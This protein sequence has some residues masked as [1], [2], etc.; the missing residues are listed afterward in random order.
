MRA[1]PILGVVA[2]LGLAAADARGDCPT[3]QAACLLR[4]EGVAL[5]ANKQYDE[6]AAKFEASIM[7]GAS[8]RAELGYALALQGAGRLG[9]AFEAI[10]EADR[11]SAWE[12]RAAPADAEVHARSERIKYVLAD[13]RSRVGFIRVQ[14]PASVAPQQ[15]VAVQRAGRDVRD[16][17]A[18]I[19]VAPGEKL[20]AVMLTGARYESDAPVAAGG[21]AV[22]V[23]PVTGAPA[24]PARVQPVLVVAH[25]PPAPPASGMRFGIDLA[26]LPGS[27]EAKSAFGPVV[28]GALIMSPRVALTLR[29]GYLPHGSFTEGTA[30]GTV[31]VSGYELTGWTGANIVLSGALYAAIEVGA[32]SLSAT[33]DTQDFSGTTTMSTSNTAGYLIY[34]AGVGL[35]GTHVDARLGFEGAL[36]GL[37]QTVGDN[38]PDLSARLMLSFGVDLY[39]W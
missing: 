34:T 11:L 22:W 31:T 1:G 20:V 21:E 4:E 15:L 8:A 23:V 13:L 38:Q 10:A 6:A 16:P 5:L 7:A 25:A 28:H 24:G 14:L 39:P 35:R 26:Y 36:A 9:L 33:T 12:V 3:G 29:L 19:A 37:G 27:G 30:S 18:V 32:T 17:R 2:A